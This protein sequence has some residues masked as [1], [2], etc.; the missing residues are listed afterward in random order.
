M[1]LY[2]GRLYENSRQEELISSLERDL[3]SPLWRG[4]TLETET[5]IN[6][7]D[8]LARRVKEGEYDSV[9]APFLETFNIS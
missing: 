7:C 3:Y 6:A 2:K 5:V 4:E 1:I 8:A 9:I